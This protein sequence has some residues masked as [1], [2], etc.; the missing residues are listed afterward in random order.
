MPV[1]DL[2]YPTE[3]FSTV[4]R[5]KEQGS[6]SLETIHQIVNSCPMLH[7][8]F[9]PPDSPFPAVLPMIGQMGS[10]A[11]PSADLGEVLDLYLHGYVSSRIINL[12]RDDPSS[13]GLPMTIAASHL[14]GLVLALTPNSHTYNYR[15]AVLFGHA[16]VVTDAAERLYAMELITDGVVPRRWAGSRVPPNA[17]ELGSTSVLRVT[18]ATGSAKIRTGGPHDERAD[19][20]DDALRG[21]VWTGVVPVYSVLGAPV[22]AGYNRVAP[23]PGYLEE[24]R[25]ETNKDTEEYAREKAVD[26]S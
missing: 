17:A 22:A 20:A 1:R 3:P 14:D 11:R 2:Q 4:K 7:V 23:V 26:K 25:N 15:S 16:A 24:W 12:T 18:I 5:H 21:R 10:F 8:S 9:Q 6:Y 13:P 19:M